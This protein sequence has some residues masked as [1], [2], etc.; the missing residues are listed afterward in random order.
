LR[1][2]VK[3]HTLKLER[4]GPGGREGTWRREARDFPDEVGIFDF[5]GSLAA[6][7]KCVL[8]ETREVRIE[9]ES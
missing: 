2:N 4:A 8:P 3:S 7:P 5:Q 6:R 9:V 1:G